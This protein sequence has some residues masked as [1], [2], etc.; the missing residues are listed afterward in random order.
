MHHKSIY[1]EVLTGC[2][3]YKRVLIPRIHMTSSGSAL[4]FKFQRTQFPIVVAFA[5][6]I[7]KSQG[8]TFKKVGILLNRPIFTHGQ[9]YVASSRVQSFDGLKYY[10]IEHRGQGHLANDERVVTKN[11]VYKEI[12]M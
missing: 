3:K 6:T 8:Q 1:C 4:P 10:I 5:M 12:L 7:N 11:I 9:L 2:S